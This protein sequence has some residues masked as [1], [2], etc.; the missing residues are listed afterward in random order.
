MTTTQDYDV[1]AAEV[2]RKAMQNITDEMAITLVRTSGSPIV[3]E[4]KD[5]STCLMDTKPEHLG[6]S[7]YVLFHVGSSLIGTQVISELVGDGSDLKPGDGWIVNDPHTAGA[8]HQGDVSVIMPTFYEGEHVGWS[9]ANM[10][11]LD[12]GGVGIS[13]Y[14]PGAHDVWQEGMLFPPVRIIREGAIDEEWEKYIAANVR[15]PGA[16]LNDIRSMI[17]ANNT[18]SRKL[19]QVIDEFGMDRHREYCEINKD[20]SEQVLRERIARMPDGVYEA[21]DWNEFDGHE[22]P[23][24]LLE[25]RLRLEVDGTDLR[26]NYSGVPQIDAFVNSTRG[27][28]FGQAMTG[29]MTVLVYGDLPVNGGLWR[30]ITV[31]LGEPGT[32]VNAVPPAPVSNAHSEV[33]MRACKLSKDVL[34]QAMAL[35]EDPVLRGRIAGQCQDGFPGNALFGINQH[36]GVSVVFYPDNAIG[37]GGGAQTIMDGQDAY[38]LTCTTGGGIPDVENHEGADPVLFLWR[39]LLPNSGGAGQ[40]RGGQ[41]LEQAYAVHYSDL[42]AGPGFNACAE[43]PPHGVGGGYP[44]SSGSFYPVRATNI[45]ELLAQS[46]LPTRERCEGKAEQVRSKVSHLRLERDDVFVA[47]SGGGGGLGDPLLREPEVVARDLAFEYV[48]REHA[49]L[50][51]GVMLAADGTLDADATIEQREKIRAQRIGST[52]AR[53]LRQPASI[54]VALVIEAGSWTCGSCGEQL[55]GTSGNWR[56]AAVAKEGPLAERFAEMGVF[57]RDRTEAPRVTLREHF[58]PGCAMSLGVDVATDE[59]ETLAAPRLQQDAVA[60]GA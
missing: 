24:R 47:L 30:P 48:T 43:V 49:E 59:L 20:L 35:S 46:V 26:Y 38:G 19:T 41:A 10:H 2:H 15:A 34:C 16:V 50:V 3:T 51:Y 56:D 1:I 6:F 25:L 9:F 52:P 54:G 12:V 17:S 14:A 8:M 44:A 55:G 39:R 58:C 27:P 40:M 45:S 23:D 4:S 53:E 11:V 32:I 5:F 28:M 29:L 13:G 21:V 7:S 60:A 33:G 31:E 42:M 22:G 36:E 37:S 57:V 18:A